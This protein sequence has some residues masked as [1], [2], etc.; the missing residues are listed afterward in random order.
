MFKQQKF[1]LPNIEISEV[2][3]LGSFEL[4]IDFDA[5]FLQANAFD[6]RTLFR[7]TGRQVFP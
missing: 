5:D 4:Q 6:N 2:I 3:N 1:S 7:S